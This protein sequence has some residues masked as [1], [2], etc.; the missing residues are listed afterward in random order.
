[1]VITEIKN[2]KKHLVGLYSDGELIM[3]IDSGMAAELNLTA[4]RDY[5]VEYLREL[6]EQSELRR[7]K[8][9]GLYLLQI[10]DY[11]CRNMRISLE[12]DFAPEAAEG[13]VKFLLDIGALNDERYART[14]ASNL[15]EHKRYGTGRIRKELYAKGLDAETIKDT[16]DEL[17]LDEREMILELLHGKF[18]RALGDK[19]SRSRT[20]ASLVRYGYSYSDIISCINEVTSEMD[21]ETDL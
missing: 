3:T 2:M 8:S 11:S 7:A 16:I 12:R 15:V 4:G 20:L 10:H 17:D 6:L 5:E 18:S 21:L 1:M 19:K 14:L 9:K 13:A